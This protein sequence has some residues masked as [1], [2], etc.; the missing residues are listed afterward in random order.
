MK[1]K[2]SLEYIII[3]DSINDN[4]RTKASELNIKLYTFEEL[5]QLGRDNHKSPIVSVC[6]IIT[7]NIRNQ[8]ISKFVK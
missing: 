4:A 1:S 2:S 3:I 7:S 5:K 8:Q 6:S